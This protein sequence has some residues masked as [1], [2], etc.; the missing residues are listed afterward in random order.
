MA[1]DSPYIWVMSNRKDDRVVLFER[2]DAHPG[3]EAFVGGST[4]A[5]VG[6][7]GTVQ[8]LL[9]E[10]LLVEIPEPPATVRDPEDASKTIPNRKKPLDLG[11]FVEP[12]PA[13]QPGQPIQ[14]GRTPDPDLVPEG[15]L[16]AVQ[17]QQDAA[18]DQIASTATVPP[19]ITDAK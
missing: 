18:P 11:S 2:D 15:A 1:T 10:G 16:K 3:G 19:P 5:K 7:N 14:L 6:K 8:N 9:R 17:K 4:V 12:F 13:N